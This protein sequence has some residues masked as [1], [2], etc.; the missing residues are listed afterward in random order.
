M[1]RFAFF[2]SGDR[3]RKGVTM[4]LL[5]LP[6]V[7]RKVGL[8]KAP[9]YAAV[10]AGTFPKPVAVGERAV[11]WVESEVDGWIADRIAERDGRAAQ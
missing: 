6:E 2:F 8:T 1:S 5:K 3:L 10:K 7:C 11:A 9:I 4:Q